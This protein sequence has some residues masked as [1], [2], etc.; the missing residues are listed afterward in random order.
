M[1][2][3][4]I[5]LIVIVIIILFTYLYNMYKSYSQAKRIKNLWPPNGTPLACPD[6]WVNKENGLCDNPLLVGTGENNSPNPIRSNDFSS[7]SSCSGINK[8]SKACLNAKCKWARRTNNPWFGVLPG[9]QAGQNCY[10]PG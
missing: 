7:F 10:C 6:Y 9:C 1:D 4:T 2:T 8:N 3:L 5:I